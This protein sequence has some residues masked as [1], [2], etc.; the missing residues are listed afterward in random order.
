MWECER[1]LCAVPSLLIGGL[2][3][4]PPTYPRALIHFR[5][6]TNGL[7]PR[8]SPMQIDGTNLLRQGAN[9]LFSWHTPGSQCLSDMALDP[10]MPESSAGNQKSLGRASQWPSAALRGKTLNSSR[11]K[12]ATDAKKSVATFASMA[13]GNQRRLHP[14]LFP[15]TPRGRASGAGGRPAAPAPGAGRRGPGRPP[16]RAGR[17]CRR[18]LA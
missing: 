11:A 1:H 18:A 2:W 13:R 14:N 7:G 16:S 3:I 9:E 6:R 5:H 8:N 4:C 17:G 15:L 10:Q 12:V